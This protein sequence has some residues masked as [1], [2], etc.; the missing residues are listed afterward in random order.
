[1]VRLKHRYLLV[2]FLYPSS[3]TGLPIKDSL[4]DILQ[5]NQPSSDQLT[6]PLLIKAIREGVAELFGDY[7]V[8]VVS[9]SL[10]VKYLSPA[11]S[12]AIIRTPRAH[13]QLVWAALTFITRLPKPINQPC[14]VRIVRVSGTIR[15]SEEEVIKRAKTTI[16]RAQ[17]IPMG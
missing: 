6:V 2:T 1:M 7:G 10:Q 4:P 5:F 13:Y 11:T 9:S 14:V 15:K 3:L 17:E 8:G 16:L 12:T